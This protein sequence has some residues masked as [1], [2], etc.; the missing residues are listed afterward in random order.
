MKY[1]TERRGMRNEKGGRGIM[2]NCTGGRGKRHGVYSE[3]IKEE[4]SER[5]TKE[6]NE[7]N[8]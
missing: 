3:R 7:G 2:K 8:A 4:R 6:L 1:C 5:N